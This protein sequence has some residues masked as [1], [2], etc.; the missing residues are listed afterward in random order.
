MVRPRVVLALGATA[1]GA[2]LGRPT[3]ILKARGQA[4]TLDDQTQA[5]ITLYPSYLLRL[6]DKAAQAEGFAMLVED[7]RA[8]HALSDGQG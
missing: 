4:F 3:P 8:A 1:A 6:P 5:L 7:L 2:V